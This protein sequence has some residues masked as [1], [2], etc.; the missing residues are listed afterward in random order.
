MNQILITNLNNDNEQKN[1][2]KNNRKFFKLQFAFSI[3]I[4]ITTISF[5]IYYIN[6]LKSNEEISKNLIG[7]YNIYK[8]YADTQKQEKETPEN[9]LFG[10]IEIP[11]I[12]L[13]YPIFSKLTEEN[14]KVSPCKFY[15]TNLKENTNICIA[16]HNYNN[17]MFFS[18][19]NQ[20]KAND[21]IYIYDN[22]GTKYTYQV[23]E[24]YEV[25]ENDLSPI[26][27]YN[28][29]EKTLTLITCNNLNN[30]RFI[31]K[32]IQKTS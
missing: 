30:N 21:E 20:L 31:I 5:S 2:K 14:L 9:N 7:N 13:Y 26:T 10:I 15:G 16:G 17:D 22:T 19:I 3:I 29:N 12:N 27:N 8:L 4:I 25:N 23:Q 11:K 24:S 6:S 28:E 1:N 32:A 18:K